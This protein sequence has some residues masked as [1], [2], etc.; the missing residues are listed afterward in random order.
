VALGVKPNWRRIGRSIRLRDLFLEVD[1]QSIADGRLNFV[2]L[3]KVK[4]HHKQWLIL[5]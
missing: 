3:D 2:S 1:Y 5:F 4:I